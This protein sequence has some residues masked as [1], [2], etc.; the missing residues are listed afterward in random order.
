[1]MTY[2]EPLISREHFARILNTLRDREDL[3][4]KIN[5]VIRE[6]RTLL[7]EDLDANSIVI[8]GEDEILDLLEII[9]KDNNGDISFFCWEADFGRDFELGDYTI[10][11]TNV[12]ISTAEKL[13]DHLVQTSFGK[14]LNE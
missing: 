5:D 1:M 9:M 6:Y 4:G 14:E 10:N 13:Y 8:G 11:G 12:D 3:V 2:S 7:R